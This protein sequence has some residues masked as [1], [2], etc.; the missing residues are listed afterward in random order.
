M[1]KFI[2]A[3]TLIL[4]ACTSSVTETRGNSVTVQSAF[5]KVDPISA[6]DAHR[7][8][9]KR[10]GYAK[11]VSTREIQTPNYIPNKYQHSFRCVP[12][13]RKTP[14]GYLNNSSTL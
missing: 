10:G 14:G 4:S 1:K 11:H 3:T 6:D 2:V 13:R 8:C 7:L 5:A 9:A 12:G